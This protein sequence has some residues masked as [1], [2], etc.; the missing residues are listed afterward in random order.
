M[1]DEAGP[2]RRRP[3]R[4]RVTMSHLAASYAPRR[5]GDFVFLH[6]LARIAARQ[7]LRAD[8]RLYVPGDWQPADR[9]NGPDD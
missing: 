9:V 2:L 4:R 3:K 8:D 7:A 1:T 6:G 5:I